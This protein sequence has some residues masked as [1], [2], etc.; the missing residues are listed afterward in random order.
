MNNKKVKDFLIAY[1]IRGVARLEDVEARA[2]S[3][4]QARKI[5][6]DL[7]C[8]DDDV[9]IFFWDGDDWYCIFDRQKITRRFIVSKN[10]INYDKSY[11]SEYY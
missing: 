8:D 3:Y 2:S 7:L 11:V 9:N 10:E 1:H 4:K 6:L 5:A